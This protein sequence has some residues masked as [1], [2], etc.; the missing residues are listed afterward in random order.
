MRK[1]E[2]IE[3]ILNSL[4]ESTAD[5]LEDQD[6]DFKQWD[7]NNINNSISLVVKM[8]ICM[9]NGGDG[10]VVFGEITR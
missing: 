4:N 3:E 6:I 8:A 10:T 9:A 1:I 5:E 7:D 2:D